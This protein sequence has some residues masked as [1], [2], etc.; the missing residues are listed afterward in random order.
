MQK[1]PSI[2]LKFDHTAPALLDE[3]FKLDVI[4]T[5]SEKEPVQAILCAEIKN[6]EGAVIEDYIAFTM[7]DDNE[8]IGPLK[9][10]NVG[11]IEPGSSVTK[12]V[13]LHGGNVT[14]SRLINITVSSLIFAKKEYSKLM[15]VIRLNIPSL[16]RTAHSR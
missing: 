15:F 10:T 6:S 12:T 5:S 2:D 16:V 11:C 3:L 13:Y 8:D 9:E 1:P 7:E 14:G 4:M